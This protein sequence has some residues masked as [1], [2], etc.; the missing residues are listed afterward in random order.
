[1]SKAIYHYQGNRQK[2]GGRGGNSLVKTYTVQA[3]V[4]DYTPIF[5]MATFKL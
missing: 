4:L 3:R 5:I 2:G 1:M